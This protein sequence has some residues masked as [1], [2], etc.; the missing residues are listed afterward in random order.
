MDGMDARVPTETPGQPFVDG[1]I[2]LKR[3]DLGLGKQIGVYGRGVADVRASI[4]NHPHRAS[5][6]Q[7]LLVPKVGKNEVRAV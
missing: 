1:R 3:I 2:G 4:D 7:S 6:Q 5:S